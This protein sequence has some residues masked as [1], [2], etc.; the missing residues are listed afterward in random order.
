ANLARQRPQRPPAPGGRQRL[1]PQPGGRARGVFQGGTTRDVDLGGGTQHSLG[2]ND[3]RGFTAP[4]S[5]TSGAIVSDVGASDGDM[6]AQGNLFRVDPRT[7]VFDGANQAGL[8]HVDV[9][10]NLTGNAA[11]VQSLYVQFLRRAGD[12]NNPQDA[13]LWVNLLNHGT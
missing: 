10:G 12:L 8:N 4:A 7:V 13:G 11:F 3:F 6:V 9:S 5:S 1:P 2:G